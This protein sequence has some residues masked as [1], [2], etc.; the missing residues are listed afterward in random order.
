MN[1]PTFETTQCTFESDKWREE[2]EKSNVRRFICQ[3]ED[4][5]CI[6][7]V[8]TIEYIENLLSEER[9]KVYEEGFEKGFTA[10]RQGIDELTKQIQSDLLKDLLDACLPEEGYPKLIGVATLTSYAKSKGIIINK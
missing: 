8:A 2:F 4:K 1:K 3:C 7:A 5:D 10:G 9:N 6:R